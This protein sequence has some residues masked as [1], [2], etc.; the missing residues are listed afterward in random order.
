VHNT[1]LYSEYVFRLFLSANVH[2]CRL[3]LPS[4]GKEQLDAIYYFSCKK[5]ED[6]RGVCVYISHAVYITAQTYKILLPHSLISLAGCRHTLFH[7]YSTCSKNALSGNITICCES[8]IMIMLKSMAGIQVGF[9][10]DFG[11]GS[12]VHST[13]G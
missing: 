11:S 1:Y 2:Q 12:T 9:K 4:E 5:C 8:R 13:R 3:A 6:G 10:S 7:L